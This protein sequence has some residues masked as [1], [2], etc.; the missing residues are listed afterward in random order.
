[1]FK[2]KNKKI[3]LIKKKLK[4]LKNIDVSMINVVVVVLNK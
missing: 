3:I 1:M 4:K 2:N